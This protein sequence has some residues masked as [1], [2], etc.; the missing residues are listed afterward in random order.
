MALGLGS[1]D[2]LASDTVVALPDA[3]LSLHFDS[4]TQQ[5]SSIVITAFDGLYPLELM[6]LGLCPPHANKHPRALAA[7]SSSFSSLSGAVA[8]PPSTIS[9]S[10]ASTQ[11]CPAVLA[12]LHHLLS[13]LEGLPQ[14][15]IAPAGPG[16]AY[17]S[18]RGAFSIQLERASTASSGEG[19]SAG[20][21]A[22]AYGGA[23]LTAA[24]TPT[25][26]PDR[27]SGEGAAGAG[28]GLEALT[29]AAV[30]A[31]VVHAAVRRHGGG[32]GAGV[33]GPGSPAST[34]LSSS[35]SSAPFSSSSTSPSPAAAAAA[36]WAQPLI[37]AHA[38]R[39]VYV[40]APAHS[41][42]HSAAAIRITGASTLQD[43]VSDLGD[44]DDDVDADFD[45]TLAPPSLPPLWTTQLVT[46]P[47][48]PL[49]DGAP[50]EP[51]LP[52]TE[53]P[54]AYPYRACYRRLGLSFTL[55]GESHRVRAATLTT[56]LPGLPGFGG[57]MR[58]ARFVVFP[59]RVPAQA[60][61]GYVALAQTALA[62]R[63]GAVGAI[64]A[65]GAV[66]G[67]DAGGA[68]EGELDPLLA[69]VVP[70][71]P[72][73]ALS[74]L[75]RAIAASASSST[76]PFA[77]APS[78]TASS[79]AGAA[80]SALGLLYS[81]EPPCAVS[82]TASAR[83][84]EQVLDAS[85]LFGGT[86]E[87]AREDAPDR[88]AQVPALA[89]GLVHLTAG[90]GL[91]QCVNLNSAAPATSSEDPSPGRRATR[92]L[93]ADGVVVE[94]TLPVAAASAPLA[95]TEAGSSVSRIASVTLTGL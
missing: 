60:V 13:P 84:V 69:R 29:A 31:L 26:S 25:P 37:V 22:V 19:K 10:L 1:S 45:S 55:D 9:S 20:S 48:D 47:A 50:G 8:L 30:T 73:P 87:G 62:S 32:F 41:A 4:I 21:V 80:G 77:N 70:G 51:A 40:V 75:A 85:T 88:K 28:V 54:L 59:R 61:A 18:P 91:A 52:A 86:R 6:G 63:A 2:P 65:A 36:A 53:V 23:Y 3:R 46:G 7:S 64:G 89:A 33:S 56:N 42:A 72:A 95:S 78:T 14:A 68:A 39:G 83:T 43:L 58:R 57:G 81:G 5:L 49:P 82:W 74:D 93:A 27:A 76:A 92:L 15:G 90:G 35:S 11:W 16:P 66:G 24:L 94:L 12:G 34:F 67:T 17:A 79:A 71:S 38:G 44:P